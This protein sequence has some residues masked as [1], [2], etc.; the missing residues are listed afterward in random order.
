[1]RVKASTSAN[2]EAA[3]WSWGCGWVLG[4]PCERVEEADE[5]VEEL[6]TERLIQ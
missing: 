2:T 5:D 1:M 3:G 6:W 4:S